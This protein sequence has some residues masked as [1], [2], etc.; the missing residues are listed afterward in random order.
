MAVCELQIPVNFRESCTEIC[1]IKTLDEIHRSHL[2]RWEESSVHYHSPWGKFDQE[3]RKT[4]PKEVFLYHTRDTL[5]PIGKNKPSFDYN[6]FSAIPFCENSPVTY[7]YK[8]ILFI[9]LTDVILKT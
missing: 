6:W 1:R 4:G 3:V 8:I 9:Q 2:A 7:Q 5:F